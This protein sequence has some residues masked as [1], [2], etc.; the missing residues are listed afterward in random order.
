MSV[1]LPQGSEP[2]RF[3]PS[4][5]YGVRDALFPLHPSEAGALH[6]P[7]ATKQWRRI[8]KNGSF[9]FYGTRRSEIGTAR[10]PRRDNFTQRPLSPGLSLQDVRSEC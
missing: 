2:S 10:P 5:R 1:R 8:K 3:S 7:R 6:R 4:P 9:G